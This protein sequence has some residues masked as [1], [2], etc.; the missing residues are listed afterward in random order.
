MSLN[1]PKSTLIQIDG[2]IG[3]LRYWAIKIDSCHSAL[4]Y[5]LKTKGH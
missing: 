1:S 3:S 5:T 4:A 2:D